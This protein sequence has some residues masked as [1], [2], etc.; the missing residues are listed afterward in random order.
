MKTSPLNSIHVK[1]ESVGKAFRT[2]NKMIY[3]VLFV[4]ALIGAIT[5]L[6]LALYKPS[7]EAYRNRK[8]SESQSA[9]FDK[10]TI[11]K[12]QNLNAEQQINI[13]TLPASQRIN[14][15]GE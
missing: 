4:C 9:R 5:S 13:K 14:P 7:D 2:H 11:E 6:N 1:L 15:F 12:I 8:L 10:V 3:F